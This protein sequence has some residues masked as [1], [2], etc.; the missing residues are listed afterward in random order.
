MMQNLLLE[1]GSLLTVKNVSLP[2]VRCVED[3]TDAA[4]GAFRF[5]CLRD[6]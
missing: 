4:G 3:S 6:V 2:K 5:V 1:A